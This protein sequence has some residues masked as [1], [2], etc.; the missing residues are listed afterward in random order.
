MNT[1]LI[2]IGERVYDRR[3][4]LVVVLVALFAS[5]LQVSSVNNLLPAIEAS[6]DAS[7]AD[8]QWIISGY[9]LALAI[10]LIPS[11]RLGDV[12]GRSNVFMWGLG[13][14]VVSSLAIG[15]STNVIMLNLLRVVQGIAAGVFTP[16]VTGLIQQLFVGQARAKAFAVFG[17]AVSVSFATGPVISGALVGLLGDDAGWRASF[18]INVPAGVVAIVLALRWL[19]FTNRK[20]GP[21]PTTAETQVTSAPTKAKRNRLDLDPFGAFVLVV[22]VLCF[23]IPFMSHDNPLMWLLV[24]GGLAT[25]AIWVLW[26]KRYKERGNQPMVNLD[27]FRIRS[28]S[29]GTAAVSFQTLGFSSIFVVLALFFQ[30]GLGMS[31]LEVGLIFLPHAIMSALASMFIGR[32]S[33][34]HG[35]MLQ[36]IASV[37]IVVG[38]IGVIASIWGMSKGMNP[39]FI[40]P[41][42]I[43]LGAG[44]GS[45]APANTTSAMHD[46]PQEA[47]G[48]ASAIQQTGQRIANAV[49]IAIIPAAVFRAERVFDSWYVGA[50]AGFILIIATVSVSAIVS[51]IFYRSSKREGTLPTSA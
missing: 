17:A 1:H 7:N 5:L 38:A 40:M 27:L 33:H 15:L 49:G 29:F 13:I 43:I 44:I 36:P 4:I 51:F 23:M 22:G 39:W 2:E 20:V 8:L 14:F 9:A 19:P 41:A 18:F 32:Y 6:F 47:G 28:L 10:M 21:G 45:F 16:Q 42:L 31:A 48:T 35:I 11:G 3:K 34:R 24:P 25:I 46:V 37:V 12:V 30:N 50:T 26:E